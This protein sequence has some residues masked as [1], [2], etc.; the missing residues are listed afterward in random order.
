[1]SESMVELTIEGQPVRV[2]AGT[3]LVD[4]AKQAGIDIPVFCYHP[5]MKPV[6]MCRMCLVE[7]GRPQRD[8]ATGELARRLRRGGSCSAPTT[9]LFKADVRSSSTF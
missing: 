3:L 5:K 1:M 8:R 6:G 2:P 4:A 9:W 7:I